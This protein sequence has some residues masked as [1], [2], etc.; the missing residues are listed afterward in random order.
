MEFRSLN[1]RQLENSV[2]DSLRK[3]LTVSCDDNTALQQ[4]LDVAKAV[5][6][7]VQLL[8]SDHLE[9]QLLAVLKQSDV[10]SNKLH[11]DLKRVFNA[12]VAEWEVSRGVIVGSEVSF[13]LNGGF[14]KPQPEGPVSHGI[15]ISIASWCF[16]FAGLAALLTYLSFS[17]S[18]SARTVMHNV[19]YTEED[20]IRLPTLSLC[21]GLLQGTPLLPQ[22]S[23][24]VQSP[25]DLPLVTITRIH[26]PSRNESTYPASVAIASE[27]TECSKQVDVAALNRM[28]SAMTMDGTCLPCIRISTPSNE[29]VLRKDETIS[30]DISVNAFLD[31][32]MFSDSLVISHRIIASFSAVL[33]N[34]SRTLVQ[35]GFLRNKSN[36][37]AAGFVENSFLSTSLEN[38][39][40]QADLFCNFLFASGFWYPNLSN[41]SSLDEVGY[42]W[43]RNTG[44]WRRRHE[45][46]SKYWNRS[47]RKNAASS[48]HVS[49]RFFYIYAS[50]QP[51][52][53]EEVASFIGWAPFG[54]EARFLFRRKITTRSQVEIS[55]PISA[56]SRMSTTYAT[57]SPFVHTRL[58][59]GFDRHVT[60]TVKVVESSY[61]ALLFG[62][63]I[64]NS[65]SLFVGTSVH[66]VIIAPI[67]LFVTAKLYKQRV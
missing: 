33:A 48:A 32:C 39:V 8:D 58:E 31:W 20:S 64:A 60:E 35:E 46:G 63:D 59:F 17:F 13:F 23:E 57:N 47:A 18:Q 51:A 3:S 25:L 61:T 21:P 42:D 30:V 56:V 28:T 11:R 24:N 62:L 50:G 22:G 55:T 19:G 12:C 29:I 66:S 2:V 10:D 49:G 53:R 7:A 40:P 36:P 52:L 1:A 44:Y 27:T 16:T 6:I 54:T 37:E 38:E 14:K 9:R 41:L 4:A 15:C 26:I 45:K 43:D 67:A 5:L 34:N 65:V